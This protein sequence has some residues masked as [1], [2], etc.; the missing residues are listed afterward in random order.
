M[1]EQ[2]LQNFL[3]ETIGTYL[4]YKKQSEE[5][6]VQLSVEEFFTQIDAESNSVAIIAKHIGGN[7]RSR[8]RDFLISDGEK[9]DRD[10]DSEFVSEMDTRESVINFM[11]EGWDTLFATLESLTTGDLGKTITIRGESHTVVKAISRSIAHTASHVGQIIFL[12]KHLKSDKWKTLSI[13]KNR[14]AG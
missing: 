3:D 7:L 5:A 13:P 4:S 11:N 12:A 6:M 10:R 2:I 9:P 1:S 8:W 14:S